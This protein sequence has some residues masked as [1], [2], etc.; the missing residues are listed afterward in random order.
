M[1]PSRT[2]RY[3]RNRAGLTQRELA[4]LAHMPQAAVARIE[5]GRVIPRADTLAKLLDFCGCSLEIEPKRGIGIDGSLIRGLLDLS[6]AERAQ[7]AA[8]SGRNLAAT[9]AAARD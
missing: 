3:A 1:A 8:A 5:T 9:L 6:D 7:T 2:L 4:R